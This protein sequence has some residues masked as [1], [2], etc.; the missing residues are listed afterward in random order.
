MPLFVH[1]APESAIKRIRR[2]GIRRLRKTPSGARALF[3]M[4]VTRNFYVSHQ[5]LRELKRFHSGPIFGIYFRVPDDEPVLAG[6]FNQPHQ[7]MTAAQAA[8]LVTGEATPGFEVLLARAILPS[9]IH[10]IRALPQTIGWRYYPESHGRKPCPCVYCQR[11]EYGGR[12]IIAARD[13]I[14]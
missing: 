12:K 5:W 1:L 2:S 4:P 10:R 9:E 8:A 11:G 13:A 3:A 14:K 7:P 6:R